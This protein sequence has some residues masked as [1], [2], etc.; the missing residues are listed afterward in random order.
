MRRATDRCSVPG[1]AGLNHE[2][3]FD[4]ATNGRQEIFFEPRYAA[5]SFRRLVRSRRSCTSHQRRRLHSE[6]DTVS[7]G[8]AVLRRHGIPAASWPQCVSLWVHRA[9][10]GQLYS[11][12]RR[13]ESVLSRFVGARAASWMQL[14][15]QRHDDESTVLQADDTFELKFDPAYR[16]CLYKNYSP[17]RFDLPFYYGL[18]GNHIWIVMFQR[19]GNVRFGTRRRGVVSL[20]NAGRS[21]PGLG[22]SIHNSRV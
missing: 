21:N 13:Q 22:L 8:R 2:H 16:D 5:M 11:R 20:P 15:T 12:A 1:V 9:I 14:C 4:G 19:S 17:M 3:I 7:P 6:L 18:F 10:L